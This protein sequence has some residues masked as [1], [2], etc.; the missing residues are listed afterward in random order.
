MP[1]LKYCQ[2][3]VGILQHWRELF[4]DY[5]LVESPWTSALNQQQDSAHLGLRWEGTQ[6]VSCTAPI[7]AQ[8]RDCSFSWT[9]SGQVGEKRSSNKILGVIQVPKQG[10]PRWEAAVGMGEIQPPARHGPTPA[11]PPSC[12]ELQ[13]RVSSVL[14]PRFTTK[15]WVLMNIL[16]N[17]AQT[18]SS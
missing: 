17:L 11:L 18:S 4:W 5:L 12:F 3:R 10:H 2:M 7:K 14:R 15:V 9:S 1:A 6:K 16:T 13:S 8:E